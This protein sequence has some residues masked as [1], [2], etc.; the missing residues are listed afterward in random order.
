M[1]TPSVLII[2]DDRDLCELM[3]DALGDSYRVQLCHCAQDAP[4][5]TQSHQPALII[6]DINLQDDNGL[7]LCQRLQG[8]CDAAVLLISGDDSEA[9]KNA[10]F[11][12]AH[13]AF[14]AKP[15]SIQ[16]LRDSAA[17]LIAQSSTRP[18]P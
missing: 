16:A 10:A 3:E 8:M 15:F 7:A 18:N 4:A 2:D 12:H 6:L 1:S 5:L 14:L 11:K 9:L 13:S 17:A